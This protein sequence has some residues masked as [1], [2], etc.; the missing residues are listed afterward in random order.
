MDDRLSIVIINYLRSY[1]HQDF[2]R[3]IG[4]YFFNVSNNDVQNPEFEIIDSQS[5]IFN[6]QII[7]TQINSRQLL[8]I[9][10][11]NNRHHI[12]HF[13]QKLQQ[14]TKIEFAKNEISPAVS[15]GLFKKF[16]ESRKNSILIKFDSDNILAVRQS[17]YEA[18]ELK[19]N[20][21]VFFYILSLHTSDNRFE[22]Q[23]I[24][25][26]GI[27]DDQLIDIPEK[28]RWALFKMAYKGEIKEPTRE[29]SH[30]TIERKK[31]PQNYENTSFTSGEDDDSDGDDDKD[32]QIYNNPPVSEPKSIPQHKEKSRLKTPEK[33]K[34]KLKIPLQRTISSIDNASDNISYTKKHNISPQT[35]DRVVSPSPFETSPRKMLSINPIRPQS[36]Q[37]TAPSNGNSQE[38]YEDQDEEEE[39][40][41]FNLFK[42]NQKINQKNIKSFQ[43]FYQLLWYYYYYD[44]EKYKKLW[45]EYEHKFSALIL[46][47]VGMDPHILMDSQNQMNYQE[48]SP[49]VLTQKK[50]VS[51]QSRVNFDPSTPIYA[52]FQNGSEDSFSSDSNPLQ[53]PKV[54]PSPVTGKYRTQ[55]ES[56]FAP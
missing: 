15:A 37:E 55:I 40:S 47:N 26:L 52:P 19:A 11:L 4:V 6:E 7:A 46:N 39:D 20:Y 9:F 34:S 38:S 21:F 44:K 5:Q 54:A 42:P 31:T 23:R 27:D 17:A 53:T 41:Q 30:K 16:M 1:I 25:R 51:K 14:L 33:R 8:F 22:D 48:Y 32:N 13:N 28:F 18:Y 36:R 56:Q 24:E 3:K 2:N 43:S 50:N 49:N 45:K 35:V 10:W 29:K 12:Y